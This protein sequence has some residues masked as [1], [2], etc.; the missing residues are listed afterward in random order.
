[1]GKTNTTTSTSASAD[2]AKNLARGDRKFIEEAGQGGIAEVEMGKLA[3]QK[4][5]SKEVKDFAKRMVDDHS[6]ANAEL[7]E[8]ASKK[9][10]TLPAD[11]DSSSR[12][13][14]DKLQ[15]L[16]GAD[17]DREYMKTMVSDHKKDVKDFQKQAKSTKDA[18]IKSFTEKTLPTLEEHLKLAQTD[19]DAVKNAR[20]GNRPQQSSM[21]STPSSSATPAPSSS[22]S[23]AQPS[24]T[25]QSQASNTG[26]KSAPK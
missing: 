10:L 26:Q 16:S 9:S 1:M 23:A 8:L 19:E 25:P 5:Q 3:E 13:E 22:T 17:F 18:D 24:A 11:M 7:K 4:A 12:R 2:A 14:Y 6:K 20:S 15:K 21:S